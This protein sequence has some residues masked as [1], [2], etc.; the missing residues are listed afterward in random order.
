MDDILL[1]SKTQNHDIMK[2]IKFLL[3]ILFICA[4]VLVSCIDDNI[5]QQRILGTWIST[6]KKDTLDFVDN[7]SFYKNRDH[8]D[9]KLFRDSI[10]IRYNGMLYIYVHPTKHKY[11]L[12]HNT[13]IIDLSNKSCYGFDLQKMT[14]IR[15]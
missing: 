12:D 10:E 7:N 6:D 15:K 13:L 4:S 2:S 3:F 5:S 11:S 9:Y 8:Y 1:Q 14:F